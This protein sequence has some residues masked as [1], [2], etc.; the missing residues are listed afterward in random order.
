[1]SKAA[2]EAMVN[3][4]SKTLPLEG[5]RINTIQPGMIDTGLAS[6]E[7]MDV[8]SGVIPC[9]RPGRL[10]EVAAAIEYFLSNDSAY[11]SGSKLR[12]AGGL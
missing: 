4:L 3:G 11:C 7:I 9:R 8:M 10:E 6:P 2:L 12:I 5:I 1:M